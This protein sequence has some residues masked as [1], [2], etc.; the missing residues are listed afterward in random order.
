M[1]ASES[2]CVNLLLLAEAHRRARAA[3]PP[4]RSAAPEGGQWGPIVW[5]EDGLASSLRAV[6]TSVEK[7]LDHKEASDAR[8]S[9]HSDVEAPCR[10]TPPPPP[11]SVTSARTRA[12]PHKGADLPPH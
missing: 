4:P 7:G 6:T 5:G 3:A 11:T 12:S 10:D 9:R 1:R 2:K 8:P